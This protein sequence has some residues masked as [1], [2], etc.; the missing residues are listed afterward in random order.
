MESMMNFL[1]QTTV[2]AALLALSGGVAAAAPAVAEA[3]LNIRAGP[4]NRYPVVAVVPDGATVDVRRCRGSWC[5]VAFRGGSGWAKRSYLAMRR[6][7][8]IRGY[9]AAPVY[10]EPEYDTYGYDYGYDYGPTVGF[11][12]VDGTRIHRRHF[13]GRTDFNVGRRDSTPGTRFGGFRGGTAIN[14]GR[15]IAVPQG[16]GFVQGPAAPGRPMGNVGN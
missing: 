7:A 8:V 3:D 4:G 2:G 6:G 5:R 9:A 1:K 12:F 15:A 14:Q 11:G 10:V 13:R 16:G